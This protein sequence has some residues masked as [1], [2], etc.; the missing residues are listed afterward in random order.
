MRGG[1]LAGAL[2][3]LGCQGEGPAVE[4]GS[5]AGQVTQGVLSSTCINVVP[6][7]TGNTSPSGSVTASG[8]LYN[9]PTY[10]PWKA[11]DDSAS[12]WLSAYNQT[13]AWLEYEFGG[14]K[15]RAARAYAIYFSNGSL[16]SRAPKSWKLEGWSGTTWVVLDTRNNQVNWAGNE[17]R[18]FT[19]ASPAPYLTYRLTVSDDNDARPGIVTVS[20]DRL[21]LIDCLSYDATPSAW[22]RLMGASDGISYVN[23]MAGDPGGRAYTTGVT[24]VGL[25]GQPLLGTT[26]SFLT[27]HYPDG[28]RVFHRQIGAPGAMTVGNA[29]ARNR[30]FEE[31]YVAGSTNGSIQGT[32]KT[33]KRDAFLTRYRYTGVWGW[34]RQLGVAGAHTEAHGVSLDAANNAFM[35]G[36]TT[37]NLDGNTLVG[38][39]DGFVAKYDAT[40]SRLWTRQFGAAQGMVKPT[41]AVADDSGNVYVSGYTNS[42]LDGVTRTG[43]QDAFIIKY[44]GSGV[45][46]WTRMLGVANTDVWAEGSMLDGAGNVYV[47]GFGAG[48]LDGLPN[49]TQ[50]RKPYLVKFNPAGVK[51]WVWEHDSGAGAWARNG[52]ADFDGIYVTGSAWGDVT[53]V[54]NTLASVAHT[55]L[56][57]VDFDGNLQFIKQQGPGLYYEEPRAV[58][59][60]GVIV[61]E[62][63]D[64][65][66]SGYVEGH[67]DAQVM[68]GDMDLFVLKLAP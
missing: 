45:K 32:P 47:T 50:G 19:I 68:Q 29:V 58:Y 16:T 12:F 67:F 40:G 22:T 66:L 61:N 2:A 42:D 6:V 49:V 14:G 25:G 28:N 52:F 3:L 8:V 56:A 36:T 9:D 5:E 13:P 43:N 51:Q 30:S 65:F 1:L 4:A 31:I 59:S 20:I 48:G 62:H 39:I 38:I 23:D 24:T 7:M 60:T 37:G 27:M 11:F 44:N 21:E 53:S 57:K 33:G 17:R 55:F 34:T 26:D 54:T 46:Q 63:G 18:E 64:I 10:V 35:V 15:K 41:R